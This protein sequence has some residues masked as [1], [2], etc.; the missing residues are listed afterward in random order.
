MSS[1]SA[2]S[3]SRWL[4]R[5]ESALATH[6]HESA[7]MLA[8]GMAFADRQLWGKARK[9]LEQAAASVV[10]PKPARRRAWRALAQMA[11]EE[12]DDERAQGCERSAAALD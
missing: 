9:L 5:L 6:G 10:L 8:A 1:G 12:G 7:V 2:R 4:P 3:V 11:R